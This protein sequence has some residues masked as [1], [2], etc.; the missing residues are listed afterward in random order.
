[1]A[2]LTGQLTKRIPKGSELTYQEVDDNWSNIETEVDNREDDLG[3]PS[4]DGQVL[5]STIAGVR[6]WVDSPL[7]GAL[8]ADT[9][10]VVKFDQN[11]QLNLNAPLNS[12]NIILD[13]TNAVPGNICAFY[14]NGNVEPDIPDAALLDIVTGVFK[15]N[16]KNGYEFRFNT[17]G[18]ID[19][20]IRTDDRIQLT[21]PF[22][23]FVIQDTQAT[24]TIAPVNGAISYEVSLGLDNNP[25]NSTPLVGYNGTDITFLYPSLTTGQTYFSFTRAIGGLFSD[26]DYYVREFIAQNQVVSL[27]KDDFSGTTIN[28]LSYNEIPNT[29]TS[30]LQNEK[31]IF[32]DILT[33]SSAGA[34][35]VNTEG[36]VDF[37]T[38]LN[39]YFV[40]V[41]VE[42]DVSNEGRFQFRLHSNDVSPPPLV[43]IF[44]N[45]N[46]STGFFQ[47]RSSSGVLS[48]EIAIPIFNGTYKIHMNS[49]ANTATLYKWDG[50]AYVLVGTHTTSNHSYHIKVQRTTS[51]LTN[52][53][54]T[55]DNLYI[56]TQDWSGK[57]PAN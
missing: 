30:I 9:G 44:Q 21:T 4:S 7:T 52:A 41:D 36:K 50:S 12:G 33:G 45:Q 6:T 10:N 56:T 57:Y 46:L 28:A 19:L 3:N 35:E 24:G 22:V 2:N 18:T 38:A 11:Y 16:V 39:D 54:N 51:Y 37:D 31:L 34:S 40:V 32:R 20:D 26:S 5:S 48:A 55:L 8:I 27:L 42:N 15:S 13:V 29:D 25:S 14:Y 1:M 43:R 17:D 49:V 53:E 23:D 47:A